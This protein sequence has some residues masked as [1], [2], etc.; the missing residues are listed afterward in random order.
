MNL[1]ELLDI[2]EFQ[3]GKEIRK[4]IENL[5]LKI[6]RFRSRKIEIYLNNNLFLYLN[7]KFFLFSINIEFAKILV[8]TKKFYIKVKNE[9]INDIKKTKNIIRKNIL[10]YSKDF[11]NGDDIIVI[12]E[13][14]N[15]IGIAKAKFN[16]N[17]IE[18][19]TYGLIA[20]IKKFYL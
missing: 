11:R 3:F 17:E 1:E 5:D 4:R 16:Y 2:V 20:K 15:L 10:E 13:N 6:K 9:F 18:N 19:S 8:E 7:P 12:D 14:N